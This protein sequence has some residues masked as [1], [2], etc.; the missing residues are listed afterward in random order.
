M[1]TDGP[2]PQGMCTPSETPDDSTLHIR[3]PQPLSGSLPSWCLALLI[4]RV[5]LC[6]T[7]AGKGVGGQGRV[8][9]EGREKAILAGIRG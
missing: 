3:S 8:K 4:T 5:H 6:E 9:E 1:C 2:Q 7:M